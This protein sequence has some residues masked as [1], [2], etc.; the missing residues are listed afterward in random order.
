MV[1]LLLLLV[2][3]EERLHAL[4]GEVRREGAR[5][6]AALGTP[7]LAATVLDVERPRLLADV[8]APLAHGGVQTHPRHPL[9][10]V[11]ELLVLLIDHCDQTGLIDRARISKRRAHSVAHLP[12]KTALGEVLTAQ[13]PVLR[14]VVQPLHDREPLLSHQLI[15]GTAARTGDI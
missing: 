3:V 10:V 15:I 1:L 13:L 14:S 4:R 7:G 12:V 9:A 6:L 8:R 11:A 5:A 2:V